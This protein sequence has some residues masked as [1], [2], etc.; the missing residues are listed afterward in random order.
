MNRDQDYD[1]D[2]NNIVPCPICLD[3]YCP[4]KEGG[5][6]PEARAY[7][8]AMVAERDHMIIDAMEKYG[9]SFVKVLAQLCRRADANNLRKIKETWPNY[10]K[11]YEEMI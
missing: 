10:W 8:A 6:C 5:E 1:E 9:G 11:D 4:S 2:G 7:H 3:V